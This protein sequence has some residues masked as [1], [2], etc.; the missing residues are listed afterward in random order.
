MKNNGLL[1]G[2][3]CALGAEWLYGLSYIFTKQAT[4]NCSALSLL[5][6]RFLFAFIVMSLLI[7]SKIVTVDLKG[8]DLRPLFLVALFCPVI[9]FIGETF[10]VSL[11][12]ASESG[13]FIACIPVATIIASTIIL[14]KKPTHIQIFGILTTLAGVLITVLTLGASSSL[15]VMGYTLLTIA[16]ISYA[17]YC[18]YVDKA[19]G[20]TEVE[21]TY[22]MLV[23]GAVVFAVLALAEAF[24]NGD[25][26][27][28]ILLP[29]K[30]RKFLI[31]A[32][33]GGV[34]CSVAAFFLS[35]MAI[36]R[37]GVNRTASFAGIAT[38]VSILS[39]VIVLHETFTI[40]QIIGAVVIIT[41]VYIANNDVDR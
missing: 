41:G 36:S 12:T 32:V 25:I 34:G 23:A 15:S 16:V 8:K 24:L 21:I 13:V 9:Y 1:K 20:F 17:L 6:W 10:G 39:G 38:V 35:N 7:L 14:H 2:C 19:S 22:M 30:D 26:R 4:Q 37:I 5:G 33:Y 28:L 3:L 40:W 18:V 31:A 27:Q 29:V 11:T